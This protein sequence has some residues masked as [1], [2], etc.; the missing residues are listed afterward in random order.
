MSR[1]CYKI[2]LSLAFSLLLFS[3]IE[4][5][6]NT[7][8]IATATN[9]QY[10]MT[11][12]VDSFTQQTGISCDIIL[13]SSG[14]LTAQI[15]EGAPYDVFVSA[16]MKYPEIL[17]TNGH[18]TKEPTI[19][20]YGKLVLWSTKYKI[21]SLSIL[22]NDTI[23]HIALANPKTAPYGE[24]AISVIKDLKIYDDIKDKL[25]YGENISQTN[26]FIL[27]GAADIGFTAK[28][29]V[30]SKNLINKGNWA[31][32]TDNYPPISQGIVSLKSSLF[33]KES[34]QFYTFIHSK[35]AQDILEEF[36]YSVLLDTDKTSND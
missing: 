21:P 27:S 14:K 22:K 25:V 29:I 4:Q 8:T 13:G 17:Y 9:M 12:L 28:S 20:A 36:G 7:L 3:C 34:E 33:P 18:T 23:R 26:Q 2:I 24:A 6:K 19:Y 1:C 32:L 16:N 15:M 35:K 31:S 5:R 30:L 10:V 11:V